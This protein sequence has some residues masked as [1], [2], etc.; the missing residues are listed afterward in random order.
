MSSSNSSKLAALTLEPQDHPLKKKTPPE[1]RFLKRLFR[2]QR[3]LRDS[4][5]GNV[6]HEMELLSWTQTL[7]TGSDDVTGHT[8]AFLG[9]V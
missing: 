6:I 9:G 5:D 2:A 8:E 7:L 1:R 4:T 3:A